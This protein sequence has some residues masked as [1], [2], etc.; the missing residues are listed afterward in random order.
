MRLSLAGVP[1]LKFRSIVPSVIKS[2][3]IITPVVI[4]IARNAKIM[5]LPVGLNANVRNC[6]RWTTFWLLSLCRLN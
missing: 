4:V 6:Y 2:H 5:K 1:D 3:G